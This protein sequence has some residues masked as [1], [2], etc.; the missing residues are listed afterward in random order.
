VAAGGIATG[1][2][3]ISMLVLGASGVSVGTR[4]IATPEASVSE[5]YKNAVV[6]SGMDD[7]VMTDRLSGTP[8]TIINTPYA[9]KIGYHQNFLEKFLSSNST[10]KK[11]F[12]MLVQ[13]RGMKKLDQAVKPGNYNNLWCAGKSVELIHEI[14]PCG[15]IIDEMESEM[16]A[17]A[18]AL[19]NLIK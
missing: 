16:I 17:A 7:I 1:D 2:A 18:G 3:I 9:K 14:K 8:C 10:T 19:N 6:D 5:S 4:F 12:K 15:Q 13:F 11:Y